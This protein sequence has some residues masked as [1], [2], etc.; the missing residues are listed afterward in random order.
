M[1][2]D[3]IQF[4]NNNN[5][6]YYQ[7]RQKKYKFYS[8]GYGC[9]LLK[10][11]FDLTNKLIEENNKLINNKNNNK[12]KLISNGVNIYKNKI[13]LQSNNGITWTNEEYSHLGLQRIYLRLKS[14]QRFTE[15]YNLLE[16]AYNL[17]FFNRFIKEDNITFIS[18]GGG[19][20]FEL[21]AVRE[22]FKKNFDKDDV[23]LIS[24]DIQES[25][26]NYTKLMNINFLKN[27]LKN[28][29]VLHKI[30]SFSNKNSKIFLILSYVR[31]YIDNEKSFL[32]IKN[33]LENNNVK[34]IFVSDR[35]K[36]NNV[37][38]ILK[39]KYN[40]RVIYLL[41]KHKGMPDERQVILLKKNDD[42]QVS[43]NNKKLSITFPNVPYID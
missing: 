5:C 27:D 36:K 35:R 28:S 7:D 8:S 16:R 1:N 3:V 23:N 10:K 41:Q 34:G 30:N 38:N 39:K 6:I 37:V 24:T 32:L 26:I 33:L 19:P 20:G 4:I 42:Y 13:A 12:T 21:I 2:N 15:T 22:F 40:I 14:F 31:A 9:K 25:W 17:N 29:D 18:L 11:I 43:N